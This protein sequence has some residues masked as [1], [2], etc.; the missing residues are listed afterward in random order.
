MTIDTAT[1]NIS[2]HSPHLAQHL[3]VRDP[4]RGDVI[5]ELPIDDALAVRSAAARARQAQPAWAALPARERARLLKRARREVVRVRN[6]IL[7]L[8]ERETGKARAD[9]VGELMAVCLDIGYLTKRAP[10]WLKPR[11]VSARPLFGKRGHIFYKPFGIVAVI[12]PWNAPLTLALGDAIPALLAGNAV[13]IKPSELTPLAVR[14]AV[15]AMNRVLPSDVLQILVGAGETGAALVDEADIVCVTGS[16]QTGRSVM[17]RASRTLTPVLLELGGKDAMIVLRDADLDRAARG[18]AWGGCLMSG[19]VCM[20]VERIYVERA[21]AEEFKRKLVEQM[22]VLRVGPNGADAEIDYGPFTSPRQIDIV[23]AQVADAERK[24]AQ[25]LTGGG[26]LSIGGHGHY[27]Q[28][29]LL[30]NVDHSMAVMTEETFGPVMGVME[31]A[32]RE[33]AIRLAND[34]RYGLS[35]S[36]WTRDV[37]RGIELAQRLESGSV[38]VNECLLSAG[39]PELPFG[40]VKQSGVGARHGGAEGLRAFCVPQAVLVERRAR[41]S[42]IAWFPHSVRYSGRME[43][44]MGVLFRW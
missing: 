9:V 33:E 13:L 23:A 44:L 27:F 18:A 37:R 3:A 25:I 31:V 43:K 36:V 15:E 17:E 7:G 41:R 11:R 2:S 34:C 42:E 12:A 35:A 16:P 29:T 6:A 38:G 21:V 4:A 26:P 28:P 40:G 8:L 39:C 20:S 24:G 1:A 19:Q 5:A 30:G 10:R 14:A 22:R 32:D